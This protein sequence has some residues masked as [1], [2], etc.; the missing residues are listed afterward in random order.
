M[1]HT[2]K[3]HPRTLKEAFGPYASGP[4]LPPEERDEPLV[5]LDLAVRWMRNFLTLVGV[6][7]VSAAI[8]LHHAGFFEWLFSLKG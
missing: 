8:G 5:T 7:A 4:I 3:R 1:N 2:E 6:V